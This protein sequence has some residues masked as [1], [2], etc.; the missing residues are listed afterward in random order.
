MT[1]GERTV[2][3]GDMDYRGTHVI[4]KERRERRC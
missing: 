3:T 1:M 2:H 4:R